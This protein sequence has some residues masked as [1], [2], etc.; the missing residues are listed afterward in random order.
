L[1]NSPDSASSPVANV[2]TSGS[3]PGSTNTP[4]QMVVGGLPGVTAVDYVQLAL[5][6]VGDYALHVLSPTVLELKLINTK[7]PDPAQVTQW[8]FVD[9]NFNLS[10]PAAS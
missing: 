8:N 1:A 9:S 5:P 10:P 3:T 2:V 6:K 4:R 7:Q